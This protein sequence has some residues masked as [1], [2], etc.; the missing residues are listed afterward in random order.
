MKHFCCECGVEDGEL[1]YHRVVQ[2]VSVPQEL[3]IPLVAEPGSWICAPCLAAAK[4][5]LEGK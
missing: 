1:R 2:L 4:A 3:E 5:N